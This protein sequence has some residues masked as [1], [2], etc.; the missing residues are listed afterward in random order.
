[1]AYI[2]IFC[3]PHDTGMFLVFETGQRAEFRIHPQI[4]E[5]ILQRHPCK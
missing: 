4:K 5:Y 3:A 1:M 2:E